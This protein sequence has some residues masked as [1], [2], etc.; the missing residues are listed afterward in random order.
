M[1][2]D[3]YTSKY[4]DRERSA[5]IEKIIRTMRELNIT[6]QDLT[7]YEEKNVSDERIKLLNIRKKQN[8]RTT[9]NEQRRR[10]QIG[11]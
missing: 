4:K 1:S 6:V 11:G 9:P 7:E 8:V 3:F 5:Q 10:A 2:G